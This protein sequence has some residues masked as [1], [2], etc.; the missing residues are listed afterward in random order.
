MDFSGGKVVRKGLQVYDWNLKEGDA[1]THAP[2]LYNQ[3]PFLE[4]NFC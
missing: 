1:E 2:S 4:A 3:I